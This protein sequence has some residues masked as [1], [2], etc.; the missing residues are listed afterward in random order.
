MKRKIPPLPKEGSVDSEFRLQRFYASVIYM[1][2]SKRQIYELIYRKAR[3]G[4]GW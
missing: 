2:E 1:P 3:I 4:H